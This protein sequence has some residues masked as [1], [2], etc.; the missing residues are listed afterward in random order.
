MGQGDLS[1]LLGDQSKMVMT[2]LHDAASVMNELFASD[3]GKVD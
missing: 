1:K 3:Q 2:S